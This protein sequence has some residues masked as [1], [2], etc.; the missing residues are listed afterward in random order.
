M[1]GGPE[2]LTLEQQSKL[3][4]HLESNTKLGEKGC[5]AC[6]HQG[7]LSIGPFGGHV[8]AL[9]A[10]GSPTERMGMNFAVVSCPECGY[11]M[12]FNLNFTEEDIL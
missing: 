2:K 1:N 8:P 6:D 4:E 7:Q 5:Y 10:D 11:T 9:E 3:M 12:L